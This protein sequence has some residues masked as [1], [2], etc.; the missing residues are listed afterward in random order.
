M[1]RFKQ[2]EIGL[3]PTHWEVAELGKHIEINSGDSPSKFTFSPTGTP[4]FKV[5]QL[6]NDPKYLRTTPYYADLEKNIPEGSII[7]P[8]RGASI[9]L[10][11]IRILAVNAFM[12]TNLMTLTCLETLL[13]EYLFYIL[14]Y[15]GLAQVA[16]TTSIPQI[17][18]KHIKPFLIPIPPIE[19]QEAIAAALSAVDE[20]LEALDKLIAKKRDMKTAAMQQLLTGKTRLPGF[21]EGVGMKQ[22]GLGEIPADWEVVR[23]EDIGRSIIG[24]TYSPANIN[25]SGTLVLRSSNVQNQK[26]AYL[27]NVHVDMEM[28]P[29]VIVQKDDILICV[30]NGS[31]RLIGKC[32]LIDENAVG[33]AFGAFMSVF[34]TE[35]AKFVFFQFQSNI[36]QNQINETMGAT[37]NQIT[38][39]DMA[40]FIIPMPTAKPEELAISAA[41]FDMD[42]EISS[43]EAQRSKTQ[44]IKQG[45]MQELLTGRTRLL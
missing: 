23:F 42:S 12:D 40:S 19:E 20:L 21:G 11:K 2:T 22:T 4:Y 5:E 16:D 26:L 8:K 13:N 27:D 38:N 33:S 1:E 28:P 39:K 36:I 44:A 15:T 18:N 10:N 41:L 29:R 7:F 17:N 43:L 31:R 25:D 32:A 45:M 6:N 9:L 35:H 3:L 24:L 37:I 34:R 30:R 14:N